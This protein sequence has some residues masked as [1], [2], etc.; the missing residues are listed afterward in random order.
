[1]SLPAAVQVLTDLPL[2]IDPDEVLRFQGY[3]KGVDVPTPDVRA[4]FDE[5]LAVGA[6]LIGPRAVARWLGVDRGGPDTLEVAG[7]TL[8]IP[9]IGVHDR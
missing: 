5:A 9:T 6:T 1:M 4:L 8:T 7:V 2:A 3:K